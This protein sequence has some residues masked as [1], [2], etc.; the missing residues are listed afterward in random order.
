MQNKHKGDIEFFIEDEKVQNA[1]TLAIA[2]QQQLSQIPEHNTLHYFKVSH[3]G[4]SSAC[5]I[6]IMPIK[7]KQYQNLFFFPIRRYTKCCDDAPGRELKQQHQTIYDVYIRPNQWRFDDDNSKEVKMP[8]NA[9][10]ACTCLD[11]AQLGLDYLRQTATATSSSAEADVV[12]RMISTCL[13]R[14]IDMADEM[15]SSDTNSTEPR[16]R[17]ETNGTDTT[18]ERHASKEMDGSDTAMEPRSSKETDSVDT[19]T[20]PRPRKKRKRQK[21]AVDTISKKLL[22]AAEIKTPES[23]NNASD[24]RSLPSGSQLNRLP[25]LTTYDQREEFAEI[26]Q[27][28]RSKTHERADQIMWANKR[29]SSD[30]RFLLRR[31]KKIES[32]KEADRS[33]RSSRLINRIASTLSNNDSKCYCGAQV[34][35]LF[36]KTRNLLTNLPGDE[37][38]RVEGA[39]KIAELIGADLPPLCGPTI[40]FHAPAVIAALW[41]KDY[42]TICKD[43][44]AER[45]AL[46][47]VTKHVVKVPY[48][49]DLYTYGVYLENG[50][51]VHGGQSGNTAS[52]NSLL[53]SDTSGIQD[54]QTQQ[55]LE[56]VNFRTPLP[57]SQETDPLRIFDNFL[58]TL[59]ENGTGSLDD[60]GI[61]SFGVDIF[62]GCLNSVIDN[63]QFF[64]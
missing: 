31:E 29:Y 30:M 1:L 7:H 39:D 18:T 25:I 23:S 28:L 64:V 44:N 27:K 13:C 21:D 3:N 17:K 57:G 12:F 51:P 42:E 37:A 5:E 22:K 45:L 2:G 46:H 38:K 16:S 56:G 55:S 9:S 20:E 19:G 6:L 41:D 47:D 58:E 43:L 35:N 14:C 61:S 52:P 15:D 11:H 10:P 33:A 36:A 48:D 4:H 40:I 49:D 62:S 60:I 54:Q 34:Y 24:C 32:D 8:Q 50:C 59:D 63:S 53:Y 26:L